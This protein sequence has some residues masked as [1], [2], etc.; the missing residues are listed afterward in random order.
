MSTPLILLPGD[1]VPSSQ[2]PAS[3]SGPLKIGSGLRL[4]SQPTTKSKSSPP[5]L[6]ATQAGILTT[7]NKRNTVSLLTFSNRRYIPTINDLVIAQVHHSSPDYFFCMVTPHTAHALLPQLAFEGVTKKT[8]PQLK[9][10]DLVYARVSSTGVG[11]GAEVE[12]TCVNPATGKS[13]P[14]GLGQINGGMVFDVST[15]MAA[16]L[17]RASSSSTDDDEGVDGIVLFSELGKKLETYGG[18]E[19]AVGRNGKVWV[20]CPEAGDAAFKV[21]I[22]IGQCLQKTDDNNL[23]Q[24]DQ[25]K[26]VAKT[27]RDMKLVS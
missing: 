9:Q 10:G 22:A 2:L 12:I 25:R 17:L 26:L 20:N 13:E 27:L 3:K 1:E 18:F 7:D 21:I 8:R 24:T 23:D 16:R 11:A 14:G 15:G 4:L 5:V 19:L 6:T